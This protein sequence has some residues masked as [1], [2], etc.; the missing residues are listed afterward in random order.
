[1]KPTAAIF[2]LD[3]TLLDTID[4]LADSMNAVLGRY[5]QPEHPVQAYR[6]FV[7]DGVG[8]LVARAFPDGT[9]S[10][11]DLPEA[12][13][14]MREEYARRFDKKTHP[15]PGIEDMLTGLA[16]RDIPVAILSNKPDDFTQL[17]VT[18]LLPGFRFAAVVGA[19]HDVPKKPD[20]S[21]ALDLA[22]R[23]GISPSGVLYI[24]DTNT[25]MQTAV[26]AGFFPVGVLWGFRGEKELRESGARELI[27]RPT[28][29]LAFFDS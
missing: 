17:T 16:G 22:R 10:E 13:G 21:A 24:G 8:K 14:A 4:D 29:L 6:T 26:G 3:G 7:G 18:R 5:G 2:D 28:D 23:L 25:D 19:K 11:E 27:A 9:L 1:V 20:P 15:Y 12:V